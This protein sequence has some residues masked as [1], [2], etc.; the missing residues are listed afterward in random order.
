MSRNVKIDTSKVSRYVL[1]GVLILALLVLNYWYLNKY[2]SSNSSLITSYQ[3]KEDE[4]AKYRNPVVAGLFYSANSLALEKSIEDYLSSGRFVKYNS[5]QPKLIIVPHAGYA[6]SAGTAAK[7]YILLQKYAKSIKNVIILG[8]SHYYGGKGA[9]LSN[10]DFFKTPLGKIRVNKKMVDEIASSSPDIQ[11]NN[12]AHRKEHSIEVQLPFIQKVLPKAQIIP[13]VYGNIAPQALSSVLQKYILSSDTILIVSADLSHYYNYN[14]AQKIDMQT[15]QKISNKEAIDEHS[16]CG[17]IGINS[18]LLIAQYNNYRP[19]MLE[20]INSGDTSGDK[21]SVVGY[22][23]WSFYPDSHPQQPKSKLEKEVESL[24]EFASLY[25]KDLR[26]IVK[27]SLQKAITKQKH[28]SPSRRS[29]PEDVFDKGASF[30]T[31]YKNGELRGC[32]GSVLPT[33]S[34]AQNIADNTYSAALEDSRFSAITE[35]E[36]PYLTYSISLLSGFEE[37]K[38]GNETDLLNQIKNNIDGIVIRDG[39]RQGVFLPS[40]WE[41]LPDKEEFFKQLKVK[42]GMNPE[43]W[44]NRIKVYRFRTVE[45]KDGN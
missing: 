43:Y 4:L 22:G 38:Y 36:L 17:A 30:V 31:I 19:Q 41:Q 6:Y 12:E 34:I 24:Q 18:A 29:F 45:V 11:V 7:A 16:S 26:N 25:K 14:D 42:A 10:A 3:V 13:I 2:L 15:A 33:M 23:S 40:V 8:P 1:W 5:S 39:D 20:L 37:I 27:T 44:N 35:D 21:S 28:Y 32:I 9:Y